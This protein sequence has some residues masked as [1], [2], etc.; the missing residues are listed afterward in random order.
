MDT[1]GLFALRRT[2]ND[3]SWRTVAYYELL[4]VRFNLQGAWHT[5]ETYVRLVLMSSYGGVAPLPFSVQ[6]MTYSYSKVFMWEGW[7]T[8]TKGKSDIIY[9]TLSNVFCM[10][11]YNW[12]KNDFNLR[13]KY[14]EWIKNKFRRDQLRLIKL[15]MKSHRKHRAYTSTY[16]CNGLHLY[17]ITYSA[18][19]TY[20]S[21]I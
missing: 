4:L 5:R 21:R 6:T 17:S 7:I 2:T 10:H 19:K 9:K 18:I 15:Y 1:F 20:R 12:L 11:N 8:L 16:F 3:N 13:L 14:V